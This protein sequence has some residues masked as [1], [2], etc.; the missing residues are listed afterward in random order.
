MRDDYSD[1]PAFVFP[2]VAWAPDAAT[3]VPWSE[4]V[5]YF[6]TP[7]DVV[8]SRWF[9]GDRR[10][11]WTFVD[12]IGRCWEVAASRVTNLRSARLLRALSLTIYFPEHRLAYEFVEC[13]P[14]TVDAVRNRLLAAVRA[15][16]KFYRWGE[17]KQRREQL[18]VA[19]RIAEMVRREAAVD[20]YEISR[21]A[22]MGMLEQWLTWKGR[23]SRRVFAVTCAMIG[24]LWL[25]IWLDPNAPGTRSAPVAFA[26]FGSAILGVSLVVRRLHD[27]RQSGGWAAYWLLW[28]MICGFIHDIDRNGAAAVVGG[29]LWWVATAVMVVWLSVLPGTPGPNRYGFGTLVPK[30]NHD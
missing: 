23:C 1:L 12:S 26:A 11:G 20:G 6:L 13:A 8:T 27:L 30:L 10:A 24:V 19:E 2:V 28:T 9:E 16:P 29:L 22:P 21:F 15:N 18:L 14:M 7:R 4:G 3:G 25:E 17:G 5:L